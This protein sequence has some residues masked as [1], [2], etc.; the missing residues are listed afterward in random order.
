MSKDFI[1]IKS[2][3]EYFEFDIAE[4]Y[5]LELVSCK[6]EFVDIEGKG[7]NLPMGTFNFEVKETLPISL[8][9]NRIAIQADLQHPYT[10]LNINIK[11]SFGKVVK[12]NF[13]NSLALFNSVNLK[14]VGLPKLNEEVGDLSITRFEFHNG[15]KLLVDASTNGTE[16]NLTDFYNFPKRAIVVNNI[17]T[18]E[19]MIGEDDPEIDPTVI[20][21]EEDETP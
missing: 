3:K 4:G 12:A 14:S 18:E 20:Y 21:E 7:E 10:R 13:D 1:T 8:P 2:F 5:T 19:W 16:C 17:L 9:T 15:E 6:R 11:N